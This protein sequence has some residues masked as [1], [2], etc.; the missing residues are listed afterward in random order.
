MYVGDFSKEDVHAFLAESIQ[1]K[2][3]SHPHVMGFLGVSLDS[4]PSPYL[5]LPFMAGGSLLAH[6]KKKRFELVLKHDSEAD[7]WMSSL[8]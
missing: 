8:L 1:M 6:L 4:G 3:F 5:V 7:V 2:K